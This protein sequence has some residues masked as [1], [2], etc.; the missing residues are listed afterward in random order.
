MSLLLFGNRTQTAR[1]APR[2]RHEAIDMRSR[3]F[4]YF[5]RTFVWRG[6]EYQVEA[7]ERCWTTGTR[8]NG[9]QMDRHHFQVRC[10]EGK[11]DLYQ[12]LL[13]NTWHIAR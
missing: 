1:P 7:V 5:P 12:D 8:R 9:G 2:R 6:H 11:F 13:H 3:R 10:A 4:G